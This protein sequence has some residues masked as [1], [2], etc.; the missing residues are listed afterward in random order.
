MDDLYEDIYDGI[1]VATVLSFYS[2]E[3]LNINGK[4]QGFFEFP[5]ITKVFF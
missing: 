4:K 5:Y 2:P 3:K 1:C